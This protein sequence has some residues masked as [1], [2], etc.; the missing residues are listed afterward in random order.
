MLRVPLE[1]SHVSLPGLTQAEGVFGSV[2]VIA[3]EVGDGA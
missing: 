2:K 1:E 3:G